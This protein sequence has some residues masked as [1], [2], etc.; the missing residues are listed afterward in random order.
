MC[1]KRLDARDVFPS[2]MEEYLS[3]YGWHF[4]KKLCEHACSRM[5]LRASGEKLDMVEKSR[6]DETMR[7]YNVDISK[8]LGYDHV[9]LYNWAMSKFYGSSVNSD[10]QLAFLVRDY[11]S[12]DEG[13]DEIAMTQYYADC[14]GKGD[15]IPWEDV[16]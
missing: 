2:G 13:Y 7:R 9:Y 10:E 11:L 1:R 6:V 8:F 12:D 4:S 16:I 5:K 3:M 15:P 14:I